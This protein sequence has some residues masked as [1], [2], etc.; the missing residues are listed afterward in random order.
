MTTITRRAH[1][2]AHVPSYLHHPDFDKATARTK[3]DP[4]ELLRDESDYETG[5]MPDETTKRY[6]A[7]MHYAAHRMHK[8]RTPADLA[9]WESAY[10][11]L[12]DRIVLGNRKLIYRAVRRRM[13]ESNRSDDL[14]GDC[15]IVLIQAV[16]SFNPWIGIR[17]STYAFTCLLRALSRQ[18]QRAASNGLHSTLSYDILPE[19]EPGDRRPSDV[20]AS[21]RPA[22]DE[23]LREDHPLLSARE[24]IV[25]TQ[26]F[27]LGDD[28]G[29][30]TLETVGKS[31]G[32]SKER[33]RQV[34]ASAL[35]KLRQ[36]LCE[37]VAARIAGR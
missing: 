17:F 36:A 27:C 24:K 21:H 23:F 32:L 20:G 25:L 35:G 18:A 6:A 37:P 10:F 15:Q 22:I 29:T 12:R 13:A 4:D 33:V 14:V 2:S 3:F 19:G 30:R 5:H 11:A 34:E 8:T 26:R 31:V 1:R 7:R 16:A 9:R 28:T